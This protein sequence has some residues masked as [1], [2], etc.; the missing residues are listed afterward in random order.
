M[1]WLNELERMKAAGVPAAR[2]FVTAAFAISRDGCLTRTRGR[3]TV[4][5]GPESLR[6][7]HQL[8]DTRGIIRCH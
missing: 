5:S 6:V 7:T 3:G 8:R 2:P 1:H 4:I